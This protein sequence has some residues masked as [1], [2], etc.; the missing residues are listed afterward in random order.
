MYLLFTNS[1]AHSC[2]IRLLFFSN[3]RFRNKIE[4]NK[5]KRIL[6]YERCL[7]HVLNIST[8]VCVLTGRRGWCGGHHS[9]GRCGRRS[10]RRRRRPPRG[11]T[12]TAARR[13]GGR[14]L[15]SARLRAAVR[16]SRTHPVRFLG[17]HRRNEFF[18][19]SLVLLLLSFTSR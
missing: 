6:M 1:N 2:K 9:C 13:C 3:T 14:W 10:S 18:N 12:A 5:K 8:G 11:L 15:G 19:F 7:I 16:R 17:T 4:K